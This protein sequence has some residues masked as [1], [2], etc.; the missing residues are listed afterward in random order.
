MNSTQSHKNR[1][2]SI[3]DEIPLVEGS[4]ANRLSHNRAS[5]PIAHFLRVKK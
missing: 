1:S 5:G 2:A 4:S 3:L